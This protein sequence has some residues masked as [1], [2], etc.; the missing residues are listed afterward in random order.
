LGVSAPAAG[1]VWGVNFTRMDQPGKLDHA[2]MQM[3]SWVPIPFGNDPTTVDRWGHLLFVPASDPA[4]IEKGKQAI[5]RGH[6]A[7]RERAYSKAFL[8]ATP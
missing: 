4:A 2:A 1:D 3:A 5:E 7:V 8:L 6:Q